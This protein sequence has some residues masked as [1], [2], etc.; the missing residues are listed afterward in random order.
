MH[1]CGATYLDKNKYESI[2]AVRHTDRIALQLCSMQ[3]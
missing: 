3:Q 1:V 2:H